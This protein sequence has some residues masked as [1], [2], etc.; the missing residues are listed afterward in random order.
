MATSQGGRSHGQGLEHGHTLS[1]RMGEWLAEEQQ[2]SQRK[3][4]ERLFAGAGSM[5]RRPDVTTAPGY[6]LRWP[7]SH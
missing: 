1:M 2:V 6:H 3:G 5:A 4:E 7:K